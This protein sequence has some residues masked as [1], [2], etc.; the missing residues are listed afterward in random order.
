MNRLARRLATVA[1]TATMAAPALAIPATTASASV[2]AIN[3][4]AFGMHWLSQGHT[5]PKMPFGAARIWDASVAW[6][7]LQPNG[8]TRPSVGGVPTGSWTAAA[9]DSTAVSRLDTLVNTYR[10]HGVDPMITL[11]VTPAWAANSCSH[12]DSTNHRDWGVGTCAPVTKAADGSDPWASYVTYLAK[13]YKGKVTYFELWNEPNL[14]NG[15]NDSVARLAAMQK[16]AQAILH[17][18]GEKLVAPGIAFTNGSPTDPA[19]PGRAWLANFLSQ[20]GGKAFDITGLH[21]YPNI[22]SAKGG[23]GPEAAMNALPAIKKVLS[24]HGV[25][26]PIWNTETNVGSTQQGTTVGGGT[27][28]AAAVARTFILATQNKIAR[29]FWYAADDRSWGGTWLENSNYSTLSTAG[30]GE[31]TVRNLLVGKAALGCTRTT[32]GTNK[33]KYTCK[34]GTTSGHKTLLA[35]W[36]T[37]GKYTLHAPAGTKASY[38]VVGAKH[39]AAKGKAFAITHTPIYLAGSFR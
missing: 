9:W 7:N 23:Y 10:S 32:V 35:I 19:A 14:R 3:A 13:R 28:G 34:F 17:Y 2:P 33:W 6:K 30:I 38:T 31:R 12:V 1:A 20:T 11:G 25:S 27:A 16:Q 24:S 36:T 5:Y 22:A 18:Y 26:H 15:Y 21:L 4:Q 37:G 29:T 8:P 39:T